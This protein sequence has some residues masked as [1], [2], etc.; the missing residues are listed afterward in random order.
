M[1]SYLLTAL[2]I[3]IALIL[4]GAALSRRERSKEKMAA[5]SCTH[6]GERNCVCHKTD[7]PEG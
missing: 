6:C 1:W 7:D 4:L 3:A 2:G 5:Y